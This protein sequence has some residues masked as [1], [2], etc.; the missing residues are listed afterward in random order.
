MRNFDY[1]SGETRLQPSRNL[2]GPGETAIP[3]APVL[4][5]EHDELC[6]PQHFLRYQH[7]SETVEAITAKISY[8]PRY[9]VFVSGDAGGLYIQIG[10]VGPDNYKSSAEKLVYGRKWRVEPNLPTSEIIQTVFLAIKKA[11]EHELRERFI[12]LCE[13]RRTTPFNG[14]Q[15]LPHMARNARCYT[16]HPKSAS[17]SAVIEGVVYDGMRFAVLNTIDLPTGQA[18]LTLTPKKKSR[19]EFAQLCNKGLTFITPSLSP[20]DVLH[21]LFEACLKSSDAHVERHFAYDGFS[22]FSREVNIFEVA[23]LS[24][25]Q[26]Q[27]PTSY[28]PEEEAQEFIGTLSSENYETDASRIPAL[29]DT[30]H[31]RALCAQLSAM[32]VSP[33]SIDQA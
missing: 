17:V 27:C 31:N 29:S 10:I 5:L 25:K 2:V 1:T 4:R 9:P 22:R 7:S 28:L 26:R 15:D 6:I 13:G 21:S 30:A 14:H 11:R 23:K 32:N 33:P 18:V 19:G 8:D 3:L 24:A 12:W 16:G 20:T